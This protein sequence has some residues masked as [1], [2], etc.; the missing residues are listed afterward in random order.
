MLCRAISKN[1]H[2]TRL[3]TLAEPTLRV[4]VLGAKNGDR[5]PPMPPSPFGGG[6]R[7]PS[8][9]R[10]CHRPALWGGMNTAIQPV[11]ITVSKY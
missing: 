6:I 2:P 3:A 11:K 5:R 9:M 7:R 10:I 1:P 4:G 8:Q